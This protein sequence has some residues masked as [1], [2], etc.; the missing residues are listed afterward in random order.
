ML[1]KKPDA[2]IDSNRKAKT[3]YNIRGVS[4]GDAF[5][6]GKQ[7][8]YA[9]N[10]IEHHCHKIY[11]ANLLEEL[12]RYRHDQRTEYDTTVSFMIMLLTLT[13]QNKANTVTKRTNPLLETF[14]VSNFQ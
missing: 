5:A 13:G 1:G 8:E 10:Y 11:F 12:K 7:L 6:L 4:S 2:V 9:I 14:T 3:N